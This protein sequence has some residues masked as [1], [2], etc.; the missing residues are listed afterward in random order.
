MR[1]SASSRMPGGRGAP[2]GGRRQFSVLTTVRLQDS[3]WGGAPWAWRV[4]E[5]GGRETRDPPDVRQ[6]FPYLF[7]AAPPWPTASHFVSDNRTSVI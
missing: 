6:R 3:V 1:G 2:D 5:P 4:E 7:R